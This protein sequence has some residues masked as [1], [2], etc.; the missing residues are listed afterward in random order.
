MWG[1]KRKEKKK[2][3]KNKERGEQKPNTLLG[4]YSHLAQFLH[5]TGRMNQSARQLKVGNVALRT[6]AERL[7]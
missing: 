3:K 5:L 4:E 2:I 7:S 1:K 6:L